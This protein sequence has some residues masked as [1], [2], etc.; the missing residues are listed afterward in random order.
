MT[1]GT[2]RCAATQSVR[3]AED[4][5]N[6]GGEGERRQSRDAK[7]VGS[8]AARQQEP[9]KRGHSA[10]PTDTS[11]AAHLSQ[12]GGAL[13][14]PPLGRRAQRAS[15]GHPARGHRGLLAP[16]TGPLTGAA[17]ESHGMRAGQEL[18]L[19]AAPAMQ[20]Q[21]HLRAPTWAGVSAP[22]RG[23]RRGTH[24]VLPSDGRRAA[25]CHGARKECY[26]EVGK[27]SRRGG[28]LQLTSASSTPH[29]SH[30]RHK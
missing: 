9:H 12:Q 26:S 6:A 21:A 17:L 7:T 28:L 13:P 22:T 27:D 11:T 3:T 20:A 2:R 10:E 1:T 25:T 16:Q 30:P 4:R 8:H 19:P 23:T 29:L 15:P 5:N 18:A 24:P 14:L